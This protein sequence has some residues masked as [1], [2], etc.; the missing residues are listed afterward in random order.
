MNFVVIVVM[1]MRLGAFSFQGLQISF[2]LS[3]KVKFLYTLDAR[4][5]TYNAGKPGCF[6]YF[7]A[8][9]ALKL[10]KCYLFYLHSIEAIV[11]DYQFLPVVSLLHFYKTD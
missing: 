7:F 1:V 3:S 5:K 9:H 2:V 4:K 11:M 8:L 6:I 10:I